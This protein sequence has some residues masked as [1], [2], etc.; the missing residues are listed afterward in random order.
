ML[1]GD[2]DHILNAN[3][4]QMMGQGMPQDEAIRRALQMRMLG[5]DIA[6]SDIGPSPSP[7]MGDVGK[8]VNSVAPEAPSREIGDDS[9]RPAPTMA[10]DPANPPDKVGKALEDAD[11]NGWEAH[12]P[13]VD[14]A[15]TPAAPKPPVAKK[16]KIV[17]KATPKKPLTSSATTAL[18][19]SE[20]P[21]PPYKPDL[22]MV[23]KPARP[24]GW[25][26]WNPRSA[27]Y[28]L[29]GWK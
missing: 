19:P 10:A 3:I 17:K 11:L 15:V 28:S 27:L 8:V 16:K 13:E 6:E 26:N 22:S 24:T 18:S 29:L 4:Q 9:W 2:G 12:S 5:P 1:N 20:R 7:M 21:A 14:A 25:S 23:A